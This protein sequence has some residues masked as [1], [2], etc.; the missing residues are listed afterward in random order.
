MLSLRR[1]RG[2]SSAS[3]SG[4]RGVSQFCR[5][6]AAAGR[7]RQ[8]A[9]PNILRIRFMTFSGSGRRREAMSILR[10]R[11]RLNSRAAGGGNIRPKPDTR[12]LRGWGQA[13][14]RRAPA[15]MPANRNGNFAANSS[16]GRALRLYFVRKCRRTFRREP[17]RGL[18][19]PPVGT[20]RAMFADIRPEGEP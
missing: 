14:R 4:V 8:G 19:G 7:A 6:A 15:R 5:A 1:Y 20:C 17:G 11:W 3:S 2:C 18:R 12:S 10:S 9:A 13:R 16:P